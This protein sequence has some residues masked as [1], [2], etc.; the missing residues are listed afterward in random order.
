MVSARLS[1]PL[2]L[3]G[4]TL[5]TTYTVEAFLGAGAFGQVYRVIH[6]YLGR[7][8]LKIFSPGGLDPARD[9]FHE[10]RVLV[11]LTHP[12][13]VRIFDANVAETAYG[14]LP[15]LAME[16][17][18]GETI[19]QVLQRRVRLGLA[20]ANALAEDL[21]AGLSEAHRLE[22]PLLHLDLTT[23][24]ILVTDQ[25]GRLHAKTAD[26]GIAAQVHPITRM[27]RARGTFYFM[28]PEM[29]EGYATPASDVY[30]L[31]FIIYWLYAGLP[32]YPVPTLP[33]RA[34][35]QDWVDAVQRSRNTPAPPL[36]QFRLDIPAAMTEL[37]AKALSPDPNQRFPNAMMFSA[38]LRGV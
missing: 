20:E 13:I 17:I 37:I 8:A 16:Y 31:G 35:A 11:A 15:Y 28:A 24:N 6:R 5:G 4:T 10:A 1:E 34:S 25:G 29:F 36:A 23:E 38:A 27:A 18:E 32:P 22:P 14:P 3:P 33:E 9:F 7:Q 30:M 12:N 26:F 2:F 21:C 19:R